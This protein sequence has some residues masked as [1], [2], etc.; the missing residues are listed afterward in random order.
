MSSNII[1]SNGYLD[2][3]SGGGWSLKPK[4]VGSLVSIIIEDGAHHY[5]LRGSHPRDT[6]AVKEA[7]RLER[8][9]I[10]KWIHNAMKRFNEHS[11]IC[12][13]IPNLLENST[14]LKRRYIKH[15]SQIIS[16]TN[17]RSRFFSE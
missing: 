8:I 3:W 11:N 12:V 14:L 1:F 4:V 16:L 5:D 2:P 15:I 17:Q 7:R 6:D 10:G 13:K 9:Y